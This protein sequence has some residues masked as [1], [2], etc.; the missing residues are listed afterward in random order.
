MTRILATAMAVLLSLCAQAQNWPA[1]PIR[2]VVR[3]AGIK[4]N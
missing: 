3:R 4:A 2:L 1:K